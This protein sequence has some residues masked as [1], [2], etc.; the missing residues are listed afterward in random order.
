MVFW[1]KHRYRKDLLEFLTAPCNGIVSHGAPFV[2]HMQVSDH[3]N[4]NKSKEKQ[5]RP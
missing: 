2:Y 4:G 5:M 3:I 1:L